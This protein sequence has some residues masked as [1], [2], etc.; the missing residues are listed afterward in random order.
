[1]RRASALA[2]PRP[3]FLQDGFD[4]VTGLC[5]IV[6]HS[7]EVGTLGGLRTDNRLRE[8]VTTQ[9]PVDLDEMFDVGASFIDS[10]ETLANA[11]PDLEQLAPV[12]AIKNLIRPSSGVLNKITVGFRHQTFA[13]L[14]PAIARKFWPRK[15]VLFSKLTGMALLR[16]EACR[17]VS[18]CL[19][20]QGTSWLEEPAQGRVRHDCASPHRQTAS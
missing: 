19:R 2:R 1:V 11:E 9:G 10:K 16:A 14:A 18:H 13:L 6:S 20:L 12:A 8:T 17:Y 4:D 15:N 5:S 3:R 7:G